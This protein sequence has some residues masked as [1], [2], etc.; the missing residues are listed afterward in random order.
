MSRDKTAIKNTTPSRLISFE[1]HTESSSL[2]IFIVTLRGFSVLIPVVVGR[3]RQH[4][5]K[6]ID[7]AEW[8]IPSIHYLDTSVN[9]ILSGCCRCWQTHIFGKVVKLCGYQDYV[10]L[11]ISKIFE[12]VGNLPFFGTS[13]WETVLV[14]E[15]LVEQPVAL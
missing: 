14:I 5:D 13:D 15:S 1:L 10:T 2:Q 3:K 8:Q 7:F 9:M 6:L 12:T 4:V 11:Q